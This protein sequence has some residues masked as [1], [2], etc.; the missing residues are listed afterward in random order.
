M[1]RNVGRMELM[2]GLAY[3]GA[4]NP[5]IPLAKPK[6]TRSAEPALAT[7]NAGI[8]LMHQS[9]EVP[10]A[11]EP[12]STEVVTRNCRVQFQTTQS[13]PKLYF[14]VSLFS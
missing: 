1:Q 7:A 5:N 3:L 14:L 8:R 6:D 11:S 12:Q 4:G 2:S 13:F 9:G 10:H